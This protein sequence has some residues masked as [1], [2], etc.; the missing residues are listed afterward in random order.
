LAIQTINGRNDDEDGGRS[1]RD[2]PWEA[3]TSM[4]SVSGFG[5]SLPPFCHFHKVA[6]GS[7]F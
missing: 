5:V 4:P 1:A 2:T 7:W 3:L 6:F